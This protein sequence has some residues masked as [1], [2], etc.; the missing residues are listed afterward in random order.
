MWPPLISGGNVT[1]VKQS[2][3]DML[4]GFNVAAAD[5]RRKC[6]SDVS[7]DINT[8]GFNVAAADQRRK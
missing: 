6:V 2:A 4:A 3:R 5:Q 8:A 1:Y 7:D